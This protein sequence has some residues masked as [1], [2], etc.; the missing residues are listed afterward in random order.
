MTSKGHSAA[1]T[2]AEFFAKTAAGLM[3]PRVAHNYHYRRRAFGTADEH[4]YTVYSYAMPIARSR[5]GWFASHSATFVLDYYE[6]DLPSRTT[7]EDASRLH[8]WAIGQAILVSV[9]PSDADE[10]DEY[11][12]RETLWRLENAT[13]EVKCM[14]RARTPGGLRRRLAN[15]VKHLSYATIMQHHA[16]NAEVPRVAD[17]LTPQLAAV[18]A[19]EGVLP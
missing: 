11:L 3:F 10:R 16:R 8:S 1:R 15:A 12:K 6:L 5:V 7:A 9:L 14:A 19:L 4:G 13:R 17:L 2:T 18:L